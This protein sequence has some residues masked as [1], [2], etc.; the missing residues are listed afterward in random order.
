MGNYIFKKNDED[1]LQPLI[2]IDYID[3]DN[4]T[5]LENLFYK[6]CKM[7]YINDEKEI[8]ARTYCSIFIFLE[9]KARGEKWTNDKDI[10]KLIE[11]TIDKVPNRDIIK[12]LIKKFNSI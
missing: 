10:I 11:T 5:D 7:F 1:M 12:S 4:I 2:T 6:S 9:A 3:Y 8:F